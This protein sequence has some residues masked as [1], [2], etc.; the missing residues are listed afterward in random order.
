MP[1]SSSS[2]SVSS[3]KS[4]PQQRHDI[5]VATTSTATAAS[6]PSSVANPKVLPYL[7]DDAEMEDVLVLVADMLIKLTEHN[8]TLP[9]HPSSLTRFH[10]RAAPNITLT[11]YL[12]RIARYTSI[13]KC[14][15]LILLVYI[16]RVCERLQGFTICGLTVHRFICAALLC[17]SKALCD[18]FNTNEHYAK[19]GGISLQEIN[20]LEKEFL[21]IIDWRLICSGSVLQ[22]YYASLVRSHNH[23]VLAQEPEMTLPMDIS[24]APQLAAAAAASSSSSL[25]SSSSS[26]SS[27]SPGS[28]PSRVPSG[29]T[30]NSTR[31]SAVSSPLLPGKRFRE[32][33][34][35]SSPHKA[36]SPHP[37]TRTADSAGR[38]SASL[39]ASDPIR[40]PI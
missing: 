20:L 12:R 26:W 6:S 27:S 1:S 11:A 35:V 29:L 33:P 4:T 28:V 25:S 13:E 9:L 32:D 14:C 21:A 8:D 16:D 37:H 7:F 30:G 39:D 5:T 36:F 23:Y 15:M 2:S 40:M 31:N 34:P 38:R 18:A 10:S 22:Q 19:V 17:A 3:K 24:S